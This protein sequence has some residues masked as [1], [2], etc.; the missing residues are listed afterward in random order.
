[1]LLLHRHSPVWVLQPFKH[2]L[3][4]LHLQRPFAPQALDAHWV[5]ALQTAPP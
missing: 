5:F 1:M 3:F 2:W 4:A